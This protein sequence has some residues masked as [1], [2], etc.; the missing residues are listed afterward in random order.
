VTP[1]PI[2]QTVWDAHAGF[3][4]IDDLD[5]VLGAWN[6]V[7]VA[8]VSVN[9]GY[10]VMPWG[11]TFHV[12]AA[13]RTALELDDRFVMVTSMDDVETA[14]AAGR[15]SVSFDL[16]GLVALDG[17]V[18]LIRVYRDLGVRQMGFA[19]NRNNRFAGG[20]HDDDAGLTPLGRRAVSEMH[21]HGVVVDGSHTGRRSTLDIMHAAEA[22]TVFSHSN[23]D[24]VH[25]HPRNLTDDQ[26]RA[27]A[28]TGGV[29]G[30]NG[31]SLF[32]GPGEPIDAIVRHVVHVADLVGTDHVG[33]GLDAVPDTGVLHRALDAAPEFWPPDAGY[34]SDI[35]S[36]QPARMP[37]V[38]ERLAEGGFGE[39]EVASVLGRNF[40]RVARAVWTTT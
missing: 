3:G 5:R 29:I 38:A 7:G 32:L 1:D 17:D 26:I 15:T 21:R 10:D 16:E 2:R 20:C 13:Y 6:E 35:R 39:N 14:A 24:A 27:C 4:A 36:V 34:G 25:Q 8:H 19:F 37:E 22:P 33:L 11:D 23:C 30:I 18:G 9:V 40:A 12:L 31:L 28:A